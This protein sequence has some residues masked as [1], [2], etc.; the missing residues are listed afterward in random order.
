[1]KDSIWAYFVAVL[2]IISI[3]TIFT[4]EKI[5]STDQHNDALLRETTE[6]AMFDAVDQELYESEGTVRIVQEKF[7]ESFLRRFAQNASL[8]NTY[9][10]EIYDINDEP[11]KVSLK[12][13][14]STNSKNAD[15]KIINFDI[16]IILW[17]IKITMKY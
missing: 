11:P 1:M 8:S 16:N 3:F 2:G 7:V 5:T 13:S 4:L 12:V 6:A 9:K 17:N 14:S 10:I 15:G